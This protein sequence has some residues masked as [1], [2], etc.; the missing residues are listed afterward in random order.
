MRILP[1]CLL[2]TASLPALAQG[3]RDPL[4]T[5]A[6]LPLQ[7]AHQLAARVGEAPCAENLPEGALTALDAVDIALCR[8]PQT[9]ES[10]AN[11]RV[12]AAQV[13]VA[14]GAWLPSL[15]GRAAI[16]RNFADSGDLTQR[17]AAL[18]L[19]WLLLDFGQRS[20]SQ[21]N[22]GRLLDAALATRDATVQN[23]FLSTLQ[24]YYTAQATRAAVGAAV[25]AERAARESLAAAELRYQVGAAAPA[26]RLQAQTAASQ[27]TLNRQRAEGDARNALGAL[28][29]TLGLPAQTALTL[30]EAADL[31]AIDAWRR[32]VESLI[33]DALARRPDLKA[34]QAQVEAA[35]AAADLARAQGRPTVSLAAGPTWQKTG[36][37]ENDGGSVGLTLNVPFFNGF[38]TTYRVRAA[39]AQVDAR[40]AQRDRLQQQV[41]LDVWKAWQ[42]LGTANQSLQTTRD[43]LASAEQSQRVALGRYKAGVGSVLDLLSAQSALASAR[44][45]RIQAEL[46]WQVSRATL[47]QA[48]GTLDYRLL[49]AAEGN[50]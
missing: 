14:R 13:G 28:A 37:L 44:V 5:D 30:A 1:I 34:A 50:P 45:Q 3:V 17:S 38:Q 24:S 49:Q 31:Q 47:A 42:N 19:S 11:A 22:A 9:H 6:L 43:L 7:S 4:A 32:D 33:G 12:Q 21:Q 26:D 35:Q 48:V 39:Q 16:A 8:N 36:P 41:A 2:L 27:A 29:F 46:D 15:D 20:A 18:T 23:L 40:V 10:W 25:E